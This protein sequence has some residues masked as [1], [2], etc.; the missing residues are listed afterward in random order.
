[1]TSGHGK[2]DA[3][4]SFYLIPAWQYII[5]RISRMIIK[6]RL[7]MPVSNRF[8]EK[9]SCEIGIV[10]TFSFFWL[11]YVMGKLLSINDLKQKLCILYGWMFCSY[12]LRYVMM[13]ILF[14]LFCLFGAFYVHVYKSSWTLIACSADGY[15]KLSFCR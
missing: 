2:I 10:F 1:M 9:F 11:E 13:L 6:I 3:L 5:S 12:L 14:F 4:E 15:Q 8:E 7:W